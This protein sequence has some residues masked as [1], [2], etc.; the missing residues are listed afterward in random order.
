MSNSEPYQ[1]ADL[2]GLGRKQLA[3]FIMRQPELWPK[4]LPK[5][6]VSKTNKATM[7][8]QLLDPANGFTKTIGV[9][10]QDPPS[11]PQSPLSDIGNDLI[12]RRKL[13]L[14]WLDK[15]L[16]GLVPRGIDLEVIPSDNITGCGPGE[17]RVD[18]ADL[19]KELDKCNLVNGSAELAYPHPA[20]PEFW[21]SFLIYQSG[22]VC[23][24]SILVES[25]RTSVQDNYSVLRVQ[26]TEN[27]DIAASLKRKRDDTD[28]DGPMSPNPGSSAQD[29][30]RDRL[31][32]TPGYPLFSSSF[33]HPEIENSQVVEIWKFVSDF[34]SRYQGKVSGDHTQMIITKTM[35]YS[36]LNIGATTVDSAIKMT[37]L[38]ALYGEDGSRKDSEFIERLKL[39]SSSGSKPEGRTKLA[40]YIKQHH[41]SY[42]AQNVA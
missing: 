24:A 34:M 5:F 40:L 33:H 18:T 37:R 1:Q 4:S 7:I 21:Q 9:T 41:D 38:I 15:R 42:L 2:Q 12:V 27:I 6:S 20:D 14:L 36:A 30:L 11:R 10:S 39:R 16:S 17:W 25:L 31:I 23:E 13:T 8:A 29:W 19:L 28:S 22:A 26:I 3:V 32:N 35:L